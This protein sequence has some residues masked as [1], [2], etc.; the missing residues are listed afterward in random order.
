MVTRLTEFVIH[1]G[2]QVFLAGPGL[3]LPRNR[4]ALFINPI[5]K[6]RKQVIDDIS[7]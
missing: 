5:K 7:M 4:F 6:T 3:D 1:Y 2:I